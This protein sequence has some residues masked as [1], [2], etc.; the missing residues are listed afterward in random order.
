MRDTDSMGFVLV[1]DG[2]RIRVAGASP[3]SHRI[4]SVSRPNASKEVK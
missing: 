3:L 4:M 1:L 2:K